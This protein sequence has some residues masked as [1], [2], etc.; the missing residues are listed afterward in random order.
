VKSDQRKRN[1]F[2]GGTVPFGWHVGEDGALIEVPEQPAVIR[3]IVELRREGLSLSAIAAK[4]GGAVSHVTVRN[5]L[6]NVT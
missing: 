1:R 6:L 2:L 4:I 5:I 3:H